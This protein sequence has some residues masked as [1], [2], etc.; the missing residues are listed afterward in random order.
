MIAST[1]MYYVAMNSIDGLYLT[2]SH[3]DSMESAGDFDICWIC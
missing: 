2:K 3:Y 1:Y